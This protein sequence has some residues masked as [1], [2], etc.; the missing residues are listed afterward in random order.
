MLLGKSNLQPDV[1]L[2]SQHPKRNI[3]NTTPINIPPGTWLLGLLWFGE[4]L[5]LIIEMFNVYLKCFI[6]LLKMLSN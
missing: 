5:W 6:Y 3:W 4:N 1:R 2:N